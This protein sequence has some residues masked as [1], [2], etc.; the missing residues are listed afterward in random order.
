VAVNL[1][2]RQ[3]DDSG[4]AEHVAESLA[5]ARLDPARLWLEITETVILE[6]APPVHAALKRLAELG[7]RLCMDDF[8]TGY[9]SLAYLH[10]MEL[11]KLKVDRSFV[12]RMESDPRS[13]QLVHTIVGLAHNLGVAV[14]A[15]G[16]ETREQLRILRGHDCDYAQG[17]LF[18]RPLPPEEG[19]AFLSSD[20]WW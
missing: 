2:A 6:S 13:A 14:V 3:F 20:L 11:H 1:S 7:V 4:L 16:V 9:S 15:E 8:G 17:F 18:A 19:E 5:A 10:R 12:S